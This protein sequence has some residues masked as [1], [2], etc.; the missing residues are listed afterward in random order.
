M[1]FFQALAAAED[2]QVFDQEDF[3]AQD[4]RVVVTGRTKALIR[5][6]GRTVENEYVHVFTIAGGKVQ[7]FVEFFDTA[8]ATEAYRKTAGAGA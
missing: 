8:A 2:I 1:E 3:I 5:S 4:D 7:R 6:T